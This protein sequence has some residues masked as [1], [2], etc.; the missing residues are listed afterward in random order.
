MKT[1]EEILNNYDADEVIFRLSAIKAINKARKE[2][3]EECA[4][5]AKI[6]WVDDDY[7]EELRDMNRHA[8]IDKSSI[9]NIIKEL[10]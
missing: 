2:A 9:L 10:K 1:A 8:E 3:I 7:N 5:R 4:E 6:V